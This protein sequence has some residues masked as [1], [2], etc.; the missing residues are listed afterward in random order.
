MY[1]EIIISVVIIV[2]VFFGD[3]F[4]I[5]YTKKTVSELCNDIYKLK[6]ALEENNN[7]T[8]TSSLQEL[9]EHIKTVHQSLAYYIE[10]DEIEKVETNFTECKS[11]VENHQYNFAI[12][13]L[14]ITVYVLEHITDKY[15]FN[16][17]NIF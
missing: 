13:K 15:S 3:I 17:E 7:E 10:H 5:N 6:Q 9:E 14:D 4:T 1:K 16:L 11:H 2:L 8:I 12:S